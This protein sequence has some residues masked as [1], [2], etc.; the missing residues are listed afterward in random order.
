MMQHLIGINYF[1]S[2]PAQDQ[3]AVKKARSYLEFAEDVIQVPRNLVGMSFRGI[4]IVKLIAV[5][6][7]IKRGRSNNL[8]GYWKDQGLSRLFRLPDEEDLWWSISSHGHLVPISWRNTV[9]TCYNNHHPCF[10]KV[11]CSCFKAVSYLFGCMSYL[12]MWLA[13]Q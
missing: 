11:L 6:L 1:C 5:I 2:I 10:C 3:D 7:E 13:S 4:F 9:F 8:Q 12:W